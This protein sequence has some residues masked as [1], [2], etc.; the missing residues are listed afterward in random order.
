MSVA[1]D[2]QKQRPVSEHASIRTMYERTRKLGIP[3]VF[4]R[5]AAQQPQ[6]TFGQQGVCCQ[7]CSHGPCRIIPGERGAKAGI[8]G[9]DADTIVARNL[10]RLAIHGAAAYSHHLEAVCDTL[11]A[12][13][14]GKAAFPIA[15]VEK[16]R[17]VADAL[18]VEVPDPAPTTASAPPPAPAPATAPGGRAAAGP[19]GVS[20]LANAVTAA[21]MEDLARPAHQPSRLVEAWAPAS[22]LEVWRRL[23]VVPGGLY[24]EIRDALTK[25]MTSIDTDPV[26]LLLTAVRLGIATGFSGLIGTITLQDAL[27][28]TPSPVRTTAD[29]GIL[30][31][32]TVNIVAHGHVPLMG[33][34]V[35]QASNDPTLLEEARAAGATGIHV[36]GSMCTGQ[37]LIQRS[38]GSAAGIRGQL[39]NWITQEFMVSTGVVDLVMLDMNCTIPGLVE[40]ASRFDTRLVS[41]D[42]VVHVPGVR[43]A[44]DYRADQAAEQARQLIRMAIEAFRKRQQ[45]QR[46]RGTEY[47]FVPSQ[48][49]EALVGFSME[50]IRSGQVQG[51]VAVVGCTNTR[52][53]HDSTAVP[54]VRE[55]I[56]RDILV[57]NA[58]CVSSAV[59]IAGL[60]RPEAAV[61]AGPRLRGLC[62]A[63]GIPPCLNF[64]SCVD[65][66][67][68][69]VAV[70]GIAQALGVD[71][72]QLPVA[73]SAPEYLE[74]KAVADG[75]F[76]ASLGLL[77]HLGP[78]PPV[79]GSPLVTEILTDKLADLLGGRFLVELDPVKAAEA[80]AAHIQ[81]KRQALGM[82]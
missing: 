72:G 17:Q 56:R 79:T 9:A 48:K 19:G 30:D 41:V 81:T 38:A 32:A 21:V 39:G 35:V 11:R 37:E 28:G 8:C 13:A 5:H 1:V 4:D 22:R 24:S 44:V 66:G 62:Q 27:L 16:L 70:A 78:V 73:A 46:E 2:T 67:R 53:G 26:D 15:G 65:I 12:A 40:A 36:Y 68:I 6:C 54:L 51:I 45:H 77:T 52:N 57:L 58:G 69:A 34:A 76:A 80:M 10:L 31:P 7:L 61:E 43:E 20:V 3:T 71:P 33:T 60:M 64:G 50:A 42:P 47:T 82:A 25:S 59:Q 23:G 49:S 63:L 55:L 74:Q 18:G 14:A 75:I 29:L